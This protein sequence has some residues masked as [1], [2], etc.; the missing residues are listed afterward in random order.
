MAAI[1]ASGR[2]KRCGGWPP[3]AAR[4]DGR[5]RTFGRRWGPAMGAEG[6][7]EAKWKGRQR[8]STRV[9]IRS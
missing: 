3:P 1:W 2:A 6:W 4:R 9:P 8:L 5:C 7:H